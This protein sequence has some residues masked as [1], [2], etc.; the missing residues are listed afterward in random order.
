M[1]A[2]WLGGEP[3]FSPEGL[4]TRSHAEYVEGGSLVDMIK[5]DLV[6]ERVAIAS[7]Q[8]II[9]WLESLNESEGFKLDRF[10]E[11]ADLLDTAARTHQRKLVQDYLGMSRQQK[12][13]ENKLWTCGYQFSKALGAAYLGC[14]RQFERGAAGAAAIR[15]CIVRRMVKRP[16]R[17]ASSTVSTNRSTSSSVSPSMSAGV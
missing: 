14:A 10:F 4:L 11:I 9:R 3:N 15:E 16:W 17:A 8:E 1:W 6:A 7:Y 12:F 13:Q 5:E 2:A